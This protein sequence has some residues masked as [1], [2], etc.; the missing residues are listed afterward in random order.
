MPYVVTRLVKM[1]R[2]YVNEETCIG[3]HLCEVYCRV[4]HSRSKNPVKAFKTEIPPPIARARIEEKRPVAFSV[5]C[6]HCEEAYCVSACISGALTRD[7]VTGIIDVDDDRCVGCWTCL[8]VCPVGAIRTDT[9][10]H[11]IVK[12]D[13]CGGDDIPSCVINCPNEA[14]TYREN[15][16]DS[17]N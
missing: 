12:C 9:A 13:L 15:N 3:C 2:V 14:L 1:K 6:Q 10:Q 8:L 4:Q 7:P 17:I 11:R 5:R 16:I